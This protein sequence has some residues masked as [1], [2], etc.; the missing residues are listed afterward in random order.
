MEKKTKISCAKVAE[1][2]DN[3]FNIGG[4]AIWDGIGRMD[5]YDQFEAEAIAAVTPPNF[6]NRLGVYTGVL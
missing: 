6:L 1:L 2:R 5:R 4:H 3:D